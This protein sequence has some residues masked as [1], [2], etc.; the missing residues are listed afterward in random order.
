MVLAQNIGID[1]G[2][3]D[4]KVCLMTLSQDQSSKIKGTRT[5]SN[6]LKGFEAFDQW[7]EKKKLEGVNLRF[8]M[9]ATGVYYEQLAY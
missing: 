9:E 7:V 3:K 1:G 6:S 4:F 2:L 5:F 8:T